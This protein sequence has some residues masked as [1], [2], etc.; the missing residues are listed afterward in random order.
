MSA[1]ACTGPAG[2]DGEA[3]ASLQWQSST[4][5]FSCWPSRCSSTTSAL[6]RTTSRW[7]PG[8]WLGCLSC[9]PY[10][11]SWWGSSSTSSTIHSHTS[12]S[13]LSGISLC[14]PSVW[15]YFS[16]RFSIS[17]YRI[18]FSFSAQNAL[19]VSICVPTDL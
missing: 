15:Q 6:M 8:L 14:T 16:C 2:I 12:R 18:D 10:L 9:S 5:W 4:L 11:S 19:H 7:W 17:T 3:G 13:T 1:L